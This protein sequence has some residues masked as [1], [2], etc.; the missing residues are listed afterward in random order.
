M[1]AMPTT[2]QDANPSPYHE[3]QPVDLEVP[4][5][6]FSHP[7]TSGPTDAALSWRPLYLRRAVLL[8]FILV[9]ILV[10]IAIESLLATSNQKNG[11]ASNSVSLHYLWTYGPTAF[12]T[13]VAALWA[14]TEYQSKL[15][16]PWIRLSQGAVPASRTLQ[17]DYVGQFPPSAIFSSL[18]NRDYTVTIALTVSIIIKILITLSTGLITLTLVHI[19]GDYPM[20]L[21]DKFIDS[22]VNFSTT[23]NL[24]WHMMRG[25]SDWNMKL[26][27]GISKD[28]A[29]QSIQ[30][31]LPDAA[32]I[33]ATVDGMA[34][35][36]DCQPA[37][38]GLLGAS[39]VD[40]ASYV[41]NVYTALLNVS[42]TSPGCN[43]SLA[44]FDG[45]YN[46]SELFARF[47]SVQ[48]DEVTG[49]A[50]RRLLLLFGNLTYDYS[51]NIT[52]DTLN[53]SILPHTG[54][55]N[56]STQ[57]LCLPTYTIG[58]V[59]VM[60]S[61]TRA[62]NVEPVQGAPVRTLN[63]VNGWDFVDAQLSMAESGK[64]DNS[65]NPNFWARTIDISKTSV[66]VDSYMEAALTNQLG[67]PVTQATT[68]YDRAVLQQTVTDFYQQFSAIIAKQSLMS[69]ESVD[70][71][72][73]ATI[74]E[75]RLMVRAWVAQWM[76]A[77]AAACIILAA[78]AV[79]TVPT[80]GFL[81][82]NPNSLTSLAFLFHHSYGLLA[83]FHSAGAVDDENLTRFLAS[84][85]LQSG[86]VQHPVS[87]EVVYR[88]FDT[89][90][91]KDED[92]SRLPQMSSK[93]L[94]PVALH[95]VCRALLCVAIIGLI[96]A[97]ELLLRK[98]TLENGLGDI[99]NDIYMHYTWTALP[100]F[101]FGLLSLAFSSMDFQIR[102]F[103]PYMTLKQY[104]TKDVFT[105]LEF[106]DMTLPAAIY[107]EIKLKNPWALVSTTALLI[108]AFFSTLSASLFQ[109]LSVPVTL[110]TTLHAKQSFSLDGYLDIES[111]Q[112]VAEISSLILESNLSFPQ[113]TYNN[114]AFPELVL[115]PDL[116]TNANLNVSA[117]SIS[118]IIPALHGKI[119]CRLY[120]S[121]KIHTNL[122]TNVSDC[123]GYDFCRIRPYL[124]R[125]VSGHALEMSMEGEEC[126]SAPPNYNYAIW[127]KPNTSYIGLMPAYLNH[128]LC[129]GEN[130]KS[131]QACS[132]K[133]FIWGKMDYSSEPIIQH[134]AAMGC[135]GS[136]EAVDVETTFLGT[137]LDIKNP[138]RSC[139]DTARNTTVESFDIGELIR[140]FAEFDVGPQDLDSF[141][142]LLTTSPWAV[143]LAALGD[144]SA[145]ADVATAIHTQYGIIMAQAMAALRVSAEQSTATL[146]APIAPGDTDARPRYAAT[147][148][149]PAGRRRVVQD[150]ASTHVL[151][152]MLAAALL[153]S[154]V[155]WVA[156]PRADVLPR[157]PT[158]IVSGLALVAGGNLMGRVPPEAGAG[159]GWR[160]PEEMV[161]ALGGPRSRFWIG[162]GLLP[163]EEGRESGGE[164]EAGVSQFGIFVVDEEEEEEENGKSVDVCD[165]NLI[166]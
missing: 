163:D 138:P 91:G 105:Q 90:E 109:E 130:C 87:S 142:T 65:D 133:L 5:P 88:V 123:G 43:V 24:P 121:S 52:Y 16:A 160:S 6:E 29:F 37:E 79:F 159:T 149:D 17:L 106:L 143:P 78:G 164:N 72:G 137:D 97:L 9:F 61:G 102:S 19:H 15:V 127:V 118:T 68:F 55:M 44:S 98:S 155:G 154:I 45:V 53:S 33:R 153:L 54:T 4:Q 8:G 119:D 31:N 58:R 126:F 21:Q 112:R 18:R 11:I 20:I 38:L 104:T 103:A 99:T 59:D 12:L 22:D 75:K 100:A 49:D 67:P 85:T 140:Y 56:N 117:V 134:I 27:D 93:T 25:L 156:S 114:L 28:Y 47:Q 129:T 161:A 111:T 108:A 7:H 60:R 32:E 95:P 84:S 115:A 26:S 77:L 39:Y 51:H 2:S 158:S 122:V 41:D 147:V 30:T 151:A 162:W 36:L 48:C 113:F 46:G 23:G 166:L 69:P 110:S 89:G 144:P 70:I 96:T 74:N 66:D 13:G 86:I 76:V 135:N 1:E 64:K 145:N 40:R 10:I 165:D 57:M 131:T 82:C 116:F 107:K 71:W 152:A 141:F 50:G 136:V 42:V 146:P 120:D 62:A 124:V 132:Q 150:P 157:S 94:H 80:R 139:E 73:S 3:Y 83:K 148:T 92:T 14:R 63:S 35:S 101:I 81:P 128:R 34:N 125:N